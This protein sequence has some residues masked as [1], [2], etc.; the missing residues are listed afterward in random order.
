M[1]LHLNLFKENS[2]QNVLYLDN[3]RVT[4]KCRSI[5]ILINKNI[6]MEK[7]ILISEW[8]KI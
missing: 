4:V 6:K 1:G 2:M 3:M 8:T 5:I 7:S